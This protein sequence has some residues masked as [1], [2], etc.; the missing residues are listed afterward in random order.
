MVDILFGLM[1]LIVLIGIA[2]LF[3]NNKG[4]IKWQQVGIGIGLQLIFAMLA[5]SSGIPKLP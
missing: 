1:G 2:Y 3:S 5:I 4:S